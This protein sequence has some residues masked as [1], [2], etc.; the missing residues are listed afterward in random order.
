[1]TVVKLHKHKQ[2]FGLKEFAVEIGDFYNFDSPYCVLQ[3]SDNHARV[4]DIS[5]RDRYNNLILPQDFYAAASWGTGK[6]K[7]SLPIIL[8]T[9]SNVGIKIKEF[10]RGTLSATHGISFM[11][12]GGNENVLYYT[13]YVNKELFGYIT[14]SLVG[15]DLLW[16]YVTARKNYTL[17]CDYTT[18]IL[19]D[20][21]TRNEATKFYE[22]FYTRYSKFDRLTLMNAGFIDSR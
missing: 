10:E 19:N 5:I 6:R 13:M 7:D 8:L 9:L 11:L 1:M 14:V 20:F 21:N 16:Q 15:L 4:V 12:A 22:D 3:Y 17:Y 2:L 18:L